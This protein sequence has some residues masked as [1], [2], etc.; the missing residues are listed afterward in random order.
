ML[1]GL[2]ADIGTAGLADGVTLVGAA[3]PQ[4]AAPQDLLEIGRTV[5]AVLE[6]RNRICA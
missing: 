5:L 2:I 6:Q 3:L 1:A 4:S